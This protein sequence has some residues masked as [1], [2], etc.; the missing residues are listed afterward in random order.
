MTDSSLVV[1][2]REIAAMRD[3]G[4]TDVELARARNYLVLGS[5]SDYET[6]GQVAGAMSTALLFRLPL[7]TIPAELARI[8]AVTAADVHRMAK[9]RL[10]PAEMTVVI[11]GDLAKIRA[12]VEKL[13]LGPVEVQTYDQ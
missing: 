11:V 12:K 7:A 5:L 9:L 10:N 3:K 2:F 8:N 13:G 4:V 6:A 1:I